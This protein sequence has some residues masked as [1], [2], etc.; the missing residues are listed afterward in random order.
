MTLRFGESSSMRWAALALGWSGFVTA[1]GV[2][3]QQTPVHIM[4]ARLAQWQFWVLE[5][6]VL[7]LLV[8]TVAN[9]RSLE[10]VL[11]PVPLWSRALI[12]ASLLALLL[13]AGVAPRT[14]RI[15]YD[16]QIYQ[17][18]GQNL[19][20]LRLAQVCNDGSVDT[21]FCDARLVST[22]SN[23]TATRMHS[24]CSIA[25]SACTN[26]WRSGSTISVRRR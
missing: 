17:H 20:D 25:L 13:A 16:E 10:R 6:H 12:G 1:L 4:R 5:L 24:A 7:L 3:L 15:Y 26:G 21:G 14:S 9:Y 23:R 2:A 22:T 19:S 11:R 18:V 8:L